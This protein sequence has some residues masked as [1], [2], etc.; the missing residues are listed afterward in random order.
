MAIL[1]QILLILGVGILVWFSYAAI[2]RNPHAFSSDNLN[3]SFFT[4]GILAL[5]LI[6]LIALLV[7]MLKHT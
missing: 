2:K 4:L 7:M 5:F 1:T 6:A 3:K